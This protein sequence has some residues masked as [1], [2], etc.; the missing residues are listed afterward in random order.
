MVLSVDEARYFQIE[1][2]D[3]LLRALEVISA[4]KLYILY[5]IN[6]IKRLLSTC[7]CDKLLNNCGMPLYSALTIYLAA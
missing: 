1:R 3:T 6:K 2:S 5:R 4:Q 7:C